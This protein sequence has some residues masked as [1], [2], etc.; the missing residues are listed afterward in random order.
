MNDN[1]NCHEVRR[2]MDQVFEKLRPD[3]SYF[4]QVATTAEHRQATHVQ[5]GQLGGGG[6]EAYPNYRLRGPR[7]T[8]DMRGR[9]H[10]P[11]GSGV[12]FEVGNLSEEFTIERVRQFEQCA[13]VR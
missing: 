13:N 9:N 10:E 11:Y 8:L 1:A 3:A 4:R 2:V 7:G 6:D 12:P 5:F